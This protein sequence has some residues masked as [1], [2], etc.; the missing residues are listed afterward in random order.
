M[1]CYEIT[2]LQ[3]LL[4]DNFSADAALWDGCLFKATCCSFVG[5]IKKNKAW[6]SINQ[7]YITASRKAEAYSVYPS[8]SNL[9]FIF[10]FVFYGKMPLFSLVL[11]KE[12]WLF[13]F[14]TEFFQRYSN[15]LLILIYYVGYMYYYFKYLL[16]L[17][18]C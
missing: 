4:W 3:M 17:Q 1:L 14:T 10:V 16:Q 8:L 18:K 15:I 6:V 12:R 2:F 5:K 7:C 9:L 11:I 13:W